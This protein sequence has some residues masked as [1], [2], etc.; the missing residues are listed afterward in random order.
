VVRV[1]CEAIRWVADEPQPGLVEVVLTDA[2]GE[3]WSLIDKAPIFDAD[4]VLRSEANFPIAVLIAC[5][6]IEKRTDRS[7]LQ[8]AVIDLLP[9]AVTDQA[10]EVAA[11][12]L[13]ADTAS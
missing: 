7:G 11:D 4:G 10:F 13:V 1:R 9:W 12:L 8:T 2:A 5:N 3:V 6:L